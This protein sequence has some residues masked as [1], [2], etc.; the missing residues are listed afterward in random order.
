MVNPGT[1]QVDADAVGLANRARMR[2]APMRPNSPRDNGVGVVMPRA[3]KPGLGIEIEGQADDVAG[4]GDI[5]T[6]DT[7]S[8]RHS[9]VRPSADAMTPTSTPHGLR[10][11]GRR[12]T[13]GIIVNGATGRIASTQ[14]LANALVADPRRRRTCRSATIGWCRACC[15]SAATPSVSPTVARAHG[16]ADWT[17]DLDAALADPDLCDLLRRGRDAA[18]RRRAAKAIA[19]GK[20]VYSEKPVAPTGALRASHCC[21]QLQRARL[22]H[23]AVEDKLY[24][25]GLQKL[26]RLVAGRRARPH[27]GLP[28]RIRLVGVRRQRPRRA[29]GR[30]GTIG[31]PAAAA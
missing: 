10:G 23:G 19:A 30:A 22:K 14:H 13:I 3:M 5:R 4:H 25:P 27:L 31:A 12:R 8:D 15:W 29:S 7:G 2:R 18:T 9:I 1:N 21:E 11:H 16:I 28:A 24:L 26:A 20:H 17:T 6:V